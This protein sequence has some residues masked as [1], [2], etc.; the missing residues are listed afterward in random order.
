MEQ[1]GMENSAKKNLKKFRNHIVYNE[2]SQKSFGHGT[3]NAYKRTQSRDKAQNQQISKIINEDYSNQRMK[4]EEDPFYVAR[5]EKVPSMDNYNKKVHKSFSQEEIITAVKQSHDSKSKDCIFQNLNA[6]VSEL[7][8]SAIKRKSM[9]PGEDSYKVTP[10][11]I[12]SSKVV[13]KQNHRRLSGSLIQKEIPEDSIESTEEEL[14]KMTAQFNNMD[15]DTNEE[16]L[17]KKEYTVLKDDFAPEMSV[18]Q[19]LLQYQMK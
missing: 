1:L 18:N 10:S 6:A 3:Y 7:N 5:L 8:G 4:V 13:G 15:E 17:K 11:I 2:T 16:T 19:E 12:S 14:A 9:L